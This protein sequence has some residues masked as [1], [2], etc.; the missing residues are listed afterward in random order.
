MSGLEAPD[1]TVEKLMKY[2]YQK[3]K[4]FQHY[5]GLRSF[6]EKYASQWL[7]KYLVYE[8][9]FDLIRLPAALSKAMKAIYD[10]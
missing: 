9:D 10:K 5:H 4:R 1:T 3:I 7:N 2:A 8:N 6:K